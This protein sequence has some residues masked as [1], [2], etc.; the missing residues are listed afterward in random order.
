MRWFAGQFQFQFLWA[1]VKFLEKKEILILIP[2]SK[3]TGFKGKL[4]DI[5]PLKD[6]TMCPASALRRLK[7]LSISNRTFCENKPVFAFKSG[8]FLTKAMFNTWLAEIL[9]DF[10]DES[11]RITGHSFRSAIP[12]ALSSHPDEQSAAVIKD[13]GGMGLF[14]LQLL[15]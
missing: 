13:W 4:L 8:K 11:H 6:K 2:Y 14:K 15:Y 7:K 1:N 10:V 12:T 3:T 5:F 9:K